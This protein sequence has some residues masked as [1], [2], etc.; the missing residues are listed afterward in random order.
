MLGCEERQGEHPWAGEP[1]KGWR[2]TR[3]LPSPL[4]FHPR[5]PSASLTSQ[6]S[7]LSEGMRLCP[8]TC[9]I[10]WCSW[11]SGLV[12]TPLGEK[13]GRSG[14]VN[15]EMSARLLL[16]DKKSFPGHHHCW[17]DLR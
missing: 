17:S 6:V 8:Q 5:D 7:C 12:G 4:C 10:Q 16:Q 3:H 11:M 15:K 13:E 1:L 9:Q 2:S 14:H